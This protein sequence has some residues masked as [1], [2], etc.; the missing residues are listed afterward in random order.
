MPFINTLKIS[1][2]FKLFYHHSLYFLS[3]LSYVGALNLLSLSPSYILYIL[4]SPI[5]PGLE[6]LLFV[7]TI[8]FLLVP[9]K[10]G[11][12]FLYLF[13]RGLC[14]S[15]PKVAPKIKK[16]SYLI[17]F[18]VFSFTLLMFSLKSFLFWK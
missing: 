15:L 13:W 9:N 11:K 18:L 12:E 14:H 8:L 7:F 4:V 10:P 16:C 3:Q 5:I 17:L 6:F 1:S 2:V